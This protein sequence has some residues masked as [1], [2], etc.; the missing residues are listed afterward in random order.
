MM[1]SGLKVLSSETS[2][3]WQVKEC[4]SALLLFA[5]KTNIPVFLVLLHYPNSDFSCIF[6]HYNTKSSYYNFSTS[7]L[8]HI[9]GKGRFHRSM[10]SMIFEPF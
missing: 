7:S 3:L 1:A 10:K 8:F 2:I 4:T 6:F 9:L 5:K